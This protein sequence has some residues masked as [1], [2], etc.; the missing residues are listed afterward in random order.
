MP[1]KEDLQPGDPEK[2]VEAIPCESFA[3]FYEKIGSE[4]ADTHGIIFRGHRDSKWKLESSLLRL[5]RDNLEADMRSSQGAIA[6]ELKW[7]GLRSKQSF[8]QRYGA[9][10]ETAASL[11]DEKMW[12]L[13]QQHGGKTPLL[14]WTTSPF[15]AAFFAYADLVL[16]CKAED[17]NG[18][19][20]VWALRIGN[21]RSILSNAEPPERFR[22]CYH[23][24][25]ANRRLIAQQGLFTYHDEPVDMVSWIASYDVDPRLN[26]PVFQKYVIQSEDYDFALS[27]LN[28]MNINY[29][30]LFPD[31]GGAALH[32]TLA[33]VQVGYEG[34]NPQE[35]PLVRPSPPSS[36]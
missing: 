10:T 35:E 26:Y 1:S 15:V 5:S 29:A 6:D 16:N 33:G 7:N 34:L 23:V 4:H 9:F 27:L 21:A 25:P 14:D 18:S 17:R 20:A 13:A 3:A 8:Q 30:T 28:R 11:E 24:L 2:A 19:V 22:L 31:I 36:T 12:A 32:A